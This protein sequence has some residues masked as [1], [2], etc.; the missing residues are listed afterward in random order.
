MSEELIGLLEELTRRIAILERRIEDLEAH[1]YSTYKGD[2]AGD[3]TTT[4]LPKKGDYGVQTTDNE[5][6]MNCNGTIRA[7]AMAAL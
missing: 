6:Q 5:L 1:H 7:T 2:Q 3:F 4:T